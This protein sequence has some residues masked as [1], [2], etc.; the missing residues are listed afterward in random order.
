MN[1]TTPILPPGLEDALTRFYVDPQP[2]A[3]FAARLQVQL[4]QR[5]LGL[6]PAGLKL[7]DSFPNRQRSLIQTLR[8][9]PILA[10]LA[11]ILA[12]LALTG[13]VYAVGR[14][15]GFIPGF[16]FTS[17]TGQVY[18]LAEPVESI[19][20]GITLRLQDAVS[21]ENRLW[22]TMNVL[23]V[24]GNQHQ[25]QAYVQT[26][27]GKILKFLSG[28]ERATQMSFSFPALPPATQA[29]TLYIINLEEQ[30]FHLPIRLRPVK[31]GEIL[32]VQPGGENPRPSDTLNGLRLVLDNVA[33]AADRTIFQ[34]SL[35]FDRPNIGIGAPW[36]ITLTNEKGQVFPVKENTLSQVSDGSSRVFETLPFQSSETIRVSLVTFPDGDALPVVEDFS[37]S[38]PSFRFDPGAAPQVGQ[39]WAL[40]E[41]VKVDQ[42]TLRV[43][44]A[45][46]TNESGLTFEF[47]TADDVTGV[48]LFIADSRLRSS[49]GGKPGP[50]KN[51]TTSLRFDSLPT[52]PFDV[53]ITGIFF[54]LHGPW[55]IQWQPPVAPP[56]AATVLSTQT[57]TLPT[58]ATPAPISS[59]PVLLEAQLLVRKFDAYLQQGPGWVHIVTE[60][61]TV[62]Q[63]RQT[64]P[65][66]YLK[67]ENWFE[68][69]ADGMMM[70]SVQTDWSSSGQILQQ[71]AT[72]GSNSTNFTYGQFRVGDGKLYPVSLDLFGINL[73]LPLGSDS[74]ILRESTTCENGSP[75]LLVT[76]RSNYDPPLQNSGEAQAFYGSCKR[77][78]IDLQTGQ[79]V[80]TEFFWVLKDGKEAYPSTSRVLLV[81]KVAAAPQEI[82]NVLA[83][84]IVP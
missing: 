22:V 82:L 69:D 18:V 26:P 57:P 62:P 8:A 34:V 47:E 64:Y 36:S 71:A 84:V 19:S 9:R 35:Q 7:I 28:T 48:R 25:L 27:D 72:V 30:N 67:T 76:L 59:D 17:N 38:P 31:S 49:M 15:S 37:S 5:H 73:K 60:S 12:L 1:D 80:K 74:T 81:E 21:D 10:L 3:A 32:P 44:G 75:C 55:T 83:K 43:V 42:F 65:P 45:K 70:R 4:H 24:T 11:A 78:W 77:V 41:T 29:L 63:P 13:I 33:P 52:E 51:F 50:G 58:Q 39:S 23:G 16:G 61:R 20:S 6:H 66:P 53:Q 54:I 56:E 68:I 46:L 2:D 14:A 40:N 79:Q